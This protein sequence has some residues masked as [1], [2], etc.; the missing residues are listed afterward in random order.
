LPLTIAA[1]LAVGVPELAVLLVN[2]NL[3]EL[4][5]APPSRKSSPVFNGAIAPLFLWK[6]LKALDVIHVGRPVIWSIARSWLGVPVCKIDNVLDA[7]P[8]SKSPA[9]Y[10]LNPVP[11]FPARSVLVI[12]FCKSTALNVGLAPPC[13]TVL[14]PPAGVCASTPEAL[15]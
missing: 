6:K 2:A 7:L 1:I 15:V 9:L 10:V 8:M 11:P 5:A 14:V 3:A 4:V 13:R 12:S